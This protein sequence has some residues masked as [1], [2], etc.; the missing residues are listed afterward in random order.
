MRLYATFYGDAFGLTVHFA[1]SLRNNLVG[2][3]TFNLLDTMCLATARYHSHIVKATTNI[4]RSALH[5]RRA[6][7]DN[8][9]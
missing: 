8:V 3:A 4:T 2:S 9:R 6:I 5:S 1:Y 7:L